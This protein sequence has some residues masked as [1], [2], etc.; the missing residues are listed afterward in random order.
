MS[1]TK[2]TIERVRVACDGGSLTLEL[3]TIAGQTTARIQI[4]TSGDPRDTR[5]RGSSASVELTVPQLDAL[6]KALL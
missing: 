4:N 1:V 2:E 5:E 3:K 6:R